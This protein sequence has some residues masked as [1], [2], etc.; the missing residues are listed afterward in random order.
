[1][2]AARTSYRLMVLS[3]IVIVGI[4]LT[5]CGGQATGV[6]RSSPRPSPT[7]GPSGLPTPTPLSTLS[8]IGL[9]SPILGGAW[10]AFDDLFGDSTCC[11]QNGWNYQGQYGPSWTGTIEAGDSANVLPDNPNSRVTGIQLDP[12]ASEQNWST[13][14]AQAML[15]QFMPPDAR[16]KSKKVIYVRYYCSWH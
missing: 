9:N 6:S 5:A 3:G 13:S 10:Q 7:M 4:L 16:Q 1:M 8:A 2:L 12:Q 15:D 11:Y 14:E